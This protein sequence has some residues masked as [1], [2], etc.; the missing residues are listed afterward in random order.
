[1]E[2]GDLAD[3]EQAIQIVAG[4]WSVPLPQAVRGQAT[5]VM[6]LIVSVSLG[7]DFCSSFLANMATEAELTSRVLNMS[8][9]IV[10]CQPIVCV[11][12]YVYQVTCFKKVT[13]ACG[14]A[15]AKMVLGYQHILRLLK[16]SQ[17]SMGWCPI[18]Y[19]AA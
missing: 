18:Q 17:T 13:F 7:G 5:L 9:L 19:I 10:V 1:V 11:G 16:H 2:V 12:C 4:H 15:K 6:S 14:S 3:L 8:I